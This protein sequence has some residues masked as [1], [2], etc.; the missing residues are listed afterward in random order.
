MSFFSNYRS[1]DKQFDQTQR[2][3]KS[4]RSSLPTNHPLLE[5]SQ[6][7]PSNNPPVPVKRTS[8]SATRP[9]PKNASNSNLNANIDEKK[10]HMNTLKRMFSRKPKTV[11]L[12]LKSRIMNRFQFWYFN[13]AYF[14]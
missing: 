14:S 7:K 2:T 9:T 3:R 6:P 1:L 4:S 13:L 11:F 5:N 10:T 8:E 12:Y